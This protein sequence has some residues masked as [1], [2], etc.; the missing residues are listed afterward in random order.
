MLLAGALVAWVALTW[1]LR[2]RMDAGPAAGDGEML[3]VPLPDS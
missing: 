3:P 2:G 1:T